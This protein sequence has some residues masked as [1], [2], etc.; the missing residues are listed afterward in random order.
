MSTE[1]PVRKIP[2]PLVNPEAQPFFDAAAEG[3]ARDLRARGDR[4]AR[5]PPRGDAALQ[6]ADVPVAELGQRLGGQCRARGGVAVSHPTPFK[7]SSS[8]ISFATRSRSR[9]AGAPSTT[10]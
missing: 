4:Q 8:F 10:R 1:I 5:V 6:R 9:A 2:A 7:Y 3:L